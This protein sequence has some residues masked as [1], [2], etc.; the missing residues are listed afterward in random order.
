MLGASAAYYGASIASA[1]PIFGASDVDLSRTVSGKPR[2]PA[3]PLRRRAACG[4]R[5]MSIARPVER[6]GARPQRQ[7]R[8]QVL[9]DHASLAPQLRR[10][11]SNLRLRPLGIDK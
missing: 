3:A 4:R 2:R 9:I 5:P 1:G 7:G 10:F 8:Q 6:P 11:F